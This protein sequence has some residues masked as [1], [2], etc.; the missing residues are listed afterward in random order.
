MRLA[1][2]HLRLHAVA[3]GLVGAQTGLIRGDSGGVWGY[4]QRRERGGDV[5]RR[6]AARGE[7]L[8]QICGLD[9][10]VA[11]ALV[12]VTQV[13]VA[14]HGRPSRVGEESN[15]TA[16]R[17]TLRARRRHMAPLGSRSA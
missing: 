11:L 6:V 17:V 12:P 10:A 5:G 9:R 14:E 3:Q 2:R 7:V 4:L 8:T 16:L 15:D 1:G 13:A